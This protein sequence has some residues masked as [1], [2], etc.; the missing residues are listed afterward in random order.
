MKSATN[1]FHIVL[2]N[3]INLFHKKIILD[4]FLKPNQ[5]KQKQNKTKQT[6]M[7]TKFINEYE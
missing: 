1:Y 3:F 2:I 6:K 4:I 7:L 5:T